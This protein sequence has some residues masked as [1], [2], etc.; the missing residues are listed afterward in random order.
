MPS[1]IVERIQKTRRY[2]GTPPRVELLDIADHNFAMQGIPDKEQRGRPDIL[3]HCLLNTLDTPLA[4]SG[5]LKVHFQVHDGRV[6]LVDAET[7]V[8][9]NYNRFLGIIA[10]LLQNNH[11][12]VE[13]PFH[14]TKIAENLTEF[15]RPQ[16]YDH[17]C[18]FSRT[19]E[20]LD[21]VTHFI[22]SIN[23]KVMVVIGAFQGGF[24][25]GKTLQELRKKPSHLMSI[26]PL[27]LTASTVASRV[28]YAYEMAM[29]REHHKD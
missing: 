1:E 22:Q 2:R 21:L 15:L 25:Q 4:R 5:M 28:M 23:S 24:F 16:D 11:V 3:H 20:L 26:S 18:I 27:G 13:K 19:G 7:R 29:N 8:P 6:F 12:P 17:V 10:Q 14:M 9:R